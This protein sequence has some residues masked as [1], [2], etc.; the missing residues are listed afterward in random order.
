MSFKYNFWRRL[1]LSRDIGIDLGTAN[2]IIHV[3]GKGVVLDEPSVVAIDLET[4]DPIAVTELLQILML[5][6]KC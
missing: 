4:G 6:K 3:S 2:T 5:R 1:Q